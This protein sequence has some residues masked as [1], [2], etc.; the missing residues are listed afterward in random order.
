MDNYNY[1]RF[2][3]FLTKACTL[4]YDDGVFEDVR[5]IE[6]MRKY[7]LKGTFNLNSCHL[8]TGGTKTRLGPEAIKELFG[9][10]TEIA[11]HG[12]SHL[13]L[14][15]ISASLM[16]RDV[17]S[18]KEHLE[19]TFEKVIRGMAYA[20]GTYS[21]EAVEILRLCDVAYS[22]TTR[23][24]E[25]FDLPDDW[26]KLHPTCHH[27]NPKLFELVDKFLEPDPPKAIQK[28]PKLF[29]LWGH[30][31]EFPR[32]NNWE[33]IEKFA[34]IMGSREDVWHA[35][36]M[37]VYDYVDAFKRLRFSSAFTYV[38]NPSVIDVYMTVNDKNILAKAGAVTKI[39]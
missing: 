9:E 23:T 37:Q 35:T 39:G 13:P 2:P 4:S 20:Y 17:V 34:K 5:L 15:R 27:N 25:A 16:V 10:D 38:E 24:T 31:Y 30:S 32:D 3:G 29:Y 18:N 12:Y 14:G 28:K 19:E 1:F 8:V 26:L 36:N 22:R 33:V 21:D 7:G 6:I 11:L